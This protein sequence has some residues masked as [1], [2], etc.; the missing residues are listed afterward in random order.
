MGQGA[1]R[2]SGF[3]HGIKKASTCVRPSYGP[4]IMMFT[5]GLSLGSRSLLA[6]DVGF[7]SCEALLNAWLLF[8][9]RVT[10]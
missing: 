9:S 2:P 3:C 4:L 1:I 10:F 8:T 5:V 7:V 6:K